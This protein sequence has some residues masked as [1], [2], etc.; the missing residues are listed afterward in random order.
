M[1]DKE[2]I[3]LSTVGGLVTLAIG[4]LI[5]RHEQ[6]IQA[7]NNA[8]TQ[9]QTAQEQEAYAEQLANAVDT[10]YASGTSETGV[11]TDPYQASTESAQPSEDSNIAQILSA[12]FPQQTS[13]QAPTTPPTTTPVTP[14]TPGVSG[15]GVDA[16]GGSPIVVNPPVTNG[17]GTQTPPVQIPV[18]GGPARRFGSVQ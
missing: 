3:I 18:T 6:T 1:T 4:Y 8:A 9:Q 14:T 5:W 16:G 2:K 12:F 11:V 15:G 13:S 10:Q 7:A 17:L